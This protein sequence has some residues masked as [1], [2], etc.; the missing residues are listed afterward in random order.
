MASYI[1]LDRYN[2]IWCQFNVSYLWFA[3][4]LKLVAVRRHMLLRIRY[5]GLF[6]IVQIGA[7]GVQRRLQVGQQRICKQY[8][9]GIIL[10]TLSTITRTTI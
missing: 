3:A 9:K 6:G 10:F 2:I 1:R 7:I 4:A 8:G 5:P